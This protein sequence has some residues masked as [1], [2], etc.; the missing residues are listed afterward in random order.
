MGFLNTRKSIV[1]KYN[2][3]YQYAFCLLSFSIDKSTDSD[4]SGSSEAENDVALP[5]SVEDWLPVEFKV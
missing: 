4:D 1:S 5:V 3:L 2:W